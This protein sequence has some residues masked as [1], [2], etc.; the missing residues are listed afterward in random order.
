MRTAAHRG[1]RPANPVRGGI[2]FKLLVFLVVVGACA[3]LAWMLFLPVF[4]AAQVRQ[5]TGFDVSIQ[6]L[7]AN[8][9]AGTIAV[10]G[11]VLTNPP[12]FPE[13]DFLRVREF[14]AEVE[15]SSLMSGPLVFEAMTIDVASLT[16]VTRADGESNA[17]RLRRTVQSSPSAAAAPGSPT[18]FAPPSAAA[19]AGRPFLIRQ[20]ALRFDRLTVV[21]F[22]AG[23]TAPD[24]R[25]FPLGLDHTYRNVTEVRSLFPPDALQPLAPLGAAIEGLV[26]GDIGRALG[27][28]ADAAAQSAAALLHEAGRKTGE[29][30][31]GFL[32]GLE[33]S[34]KP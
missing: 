31:K 30:V 3:A 32:D 7:A 1:R 27:D 28:G 12:D 23:Q 10:H 5:R 26:S 24:V 6:S 8:P 13:R 17:A 16:I 21:D 25:A 9:F 34:K 33:E 19:P 22:S 2:L 20:L 29:K 4:A 11:L 15:L 14:R 18:P